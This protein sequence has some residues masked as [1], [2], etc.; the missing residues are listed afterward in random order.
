MHAWMRRAFFSLRRCA[1]ADTGDDATAMASDAS[2]RGPEMSRNARLWSSFSSLDLAGLWP[3]QVE[4]QVA[5]MLVSLTSSDWHTEIVGKAA[6]AHR[7]TRIATVSA[8]ATPTTSHRT[9]PGHTTIL[10]I[11]HHASS[12]LRPQRG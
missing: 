12:P 2:Q 7:V 6:A 1:S 10:L 3:K 8:T 11:K 9:T 4:R 5:C